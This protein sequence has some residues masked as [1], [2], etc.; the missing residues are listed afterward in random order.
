[1]ATWNGFFHFGPLVED[2]GVVRITPVSREDA[3]DKLSSPPNELGSDVEAVMRT[4]GCHPQAAW[5]DYEALD[6]EPAKH[7]K[8]LAKHTELIEP[9][10]LV[11]MMVEGLQE[12][13]ND[14]IQKFWD[15]TFG[16]DPKVTVNENGESMAE[17]DDE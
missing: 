9:S 12:Y 2:E 13:D 5:N 3:L 6:V 1:M 17:Y 14:E 7:T 11:G 8:L 4:N 16:I 10:E 15:R